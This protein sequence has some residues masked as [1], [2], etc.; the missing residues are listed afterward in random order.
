MHD[1]RWRIQDD[2]VSPMNRVIGGGQ[3]NPEHVALEM[4]KLDPYYQDQQL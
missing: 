2:P 1:S 4:A 3:Q